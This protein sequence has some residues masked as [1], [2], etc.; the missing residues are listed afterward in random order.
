MCLLLATSGNTCPSFG[1]TE[2]AESYAEEER[3]LLR[4]L[5]LT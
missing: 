3:S 2:R 5:F 1:H 4:E